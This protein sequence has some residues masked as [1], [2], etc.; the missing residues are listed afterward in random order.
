MSAEKELTMASSNHAYESDFW[1]VG[2]LF[3]P[4]WKPRDN[5]EHA[6]QLDE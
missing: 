5:K 2:Q 6:Y 1:F 4:G 3:D